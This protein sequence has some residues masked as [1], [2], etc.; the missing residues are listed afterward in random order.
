MVAPRSLANEGLSVCYQMRQ[1][2]VMPKRGIPI[3][4]FSV[5]Q[6]ASLSS[7]NSIS[8]SS[9]SYVTHQ[10]WDLDVPTSQL[11][12]YLHLPHLSQRQLPFSS[13]GLETLPSF[14][15]HSHTNS[16][17]PLHSTV[18]P[19]PSIQLLLC[20]P[21]IPS[22]YHHPCSYRGNSLTAALKVVSVPLQELFRSYRDWTWW[23][24]AHSYVR[25][26]IEL[27]WTL[28]AHFVFSHN[29][30]TPASQ[31]LKRSKHTRTLVAVA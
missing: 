9:S 6:P 25:F 26:P 12:F 31:F 14:L 13:L 23:G 19:N 2:S 7:T 5:A 1:G 21:L 27:R 8:L 22:A 3:W 15:T 29:L 11:V 30:Q 10:N 4:S 28:S 18:S 16:A 24:S 17:N 20:L